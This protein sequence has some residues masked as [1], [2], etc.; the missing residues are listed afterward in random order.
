M[1]DRVSHLENKIEELVGDSVAVQELKYRLAV[2]KELLIIKKELEILTRDV[3]SSRKVEET[4]LKSLSNL[5]QAIDDLEDKLNTVSDKAETTAN[6]LD[7]S[8]TAPISRLKTWFWRTVFTAALVCIFARI[9]IESSVVKGLV[10][11]LIQ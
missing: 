8:V 5:H 3:E 2:E 4:T 10:K 7:I 6:A 9:G 11:A 1:E